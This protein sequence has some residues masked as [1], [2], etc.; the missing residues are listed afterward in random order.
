MSCGAYMHAV[1]ETVDAR[2]MAADPGAEQPLEA[3]ARHDRMPDEQDDDSNGAAGA[4]MKRD[5]VRKPVRRSKAQPARMRSG[6]PVVMGSLIFVTV[7]LV[8]AGATVFF[9]TKPPDDERLFQDG[10]KQV[11][12]GQFAFAVK[13]LSQAA[14][15]RPKDA[16]IYLALAR[17]Y[18]GIDQV[19]KAWECVNQAQQ[20]GA[21]VATDPALASELAN[22]YKQR[23]QFEKAINLLRPLA[24]AGVEGKRAELSDI[25]AMW[26][27]E[28]LRD[29]KVDLA[30]RCWEEVRDLG[31][32]S[33]SGEA[34]AR[35]ATIYQKLAN[36]YA[37]DTNKD[38]DDDALKYLNKLNN[39]AQNPKNYEMAA[40]LYEKQGQLELAIDQM[41]KASRLAGKN[42]VYDR[43]LAALLSRRGK[44]L[45]DEGN[46]DA[47]YGYLQQAKTVSSD[48]SLPPVALRNLNVTVDRY[49]HM[50]QISGEVW[51]PGDNSINALTLKVE[52]FD[53]VNS[54]V[55][56]TKDQRLVDEFVPALGSH[57]SKPFEMSSAVAC[58]N[59]GSNE[60]RVYLDGG[61]YKEYPIGKKDENATQ[62]KLPAELGSAPKYGVRKKTF[63]PRDASEHMPAAAPP[64]VREEQTVPATAPNLL[65]PPQTPT[66]A[67]PPPT[68]RTGSGSSE[69]KTM[70]DLD[71]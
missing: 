8:F 39:I 14:A 19:D 4:T 33:R 15:L 69:E 66:A 61:L 27:D 38:N 20:L 11:A 21:G 40:D 50:P 65:A 71:Q 63:V 13:T 54:K 37:S 68:G 49:S 70:K 64:V 5:S 3:P 57:E 10:M 24:K 62:A 31:E 41:R 42:P 44:E 18:V 30:L 26:G 35:L 43:K 51:N 12:D 53:P 9:L 34:E 25:D 46:T 28:A 59:D 29:G 48:S 1:P 45:L 32:G 7:L 22:Y 55:L 36:T 6:F 67:T 23:S 56:W 2:Q 47:G 60:F 52:L 16:R 17:A 58:K